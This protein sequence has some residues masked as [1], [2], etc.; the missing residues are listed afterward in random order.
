VNRTDAA[1]TGRSTVFMVLREGRLVF[2][3][4][5]ADLEASTD[6]YVSKFVKRPE[7]EAA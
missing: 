4:N 5:Q 7:K 1:G 2:E 6:P 3:G